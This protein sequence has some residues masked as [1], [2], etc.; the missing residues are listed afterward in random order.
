[1]SDA[2]IDWEQLDMIADGFTEDFVEI[3]REFEVDL[4]RILRD[5]ATALAAG[6]AT[7]LSRSAHQ[8]KGSAAN[9]GFTGFSGVMARIETQAKAGSVA[10]LDGELQT[11]GR[12]FSESL[13]EVKSQRGI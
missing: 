5:A 10:G 2:A 1:M 4:P 8:A 7:Q 6:D 3:Y 9:F 12:I 13:A 11:A